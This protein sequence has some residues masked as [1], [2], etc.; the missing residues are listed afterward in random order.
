MFAFLLLVPLPQLECN[1]GYE[2]AAKEIT[3]I[4]DVILKNDKR[5]LP[6]VPN[7]NMPRQMEV[8]VAIQSIYDVSEQDSS[9]K[10]SYLLTLNWLDS[11]LMF[12]PIN[13]TSHLLQELQVDLDTV[14]DS[15]ELESSDIFF[16]N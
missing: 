9:F 1:F 11:R 16:S 5:L 10:V 12:S 14:K 4:L 15:G 6:P 8:F 7:R 13:V 2:N 3:E